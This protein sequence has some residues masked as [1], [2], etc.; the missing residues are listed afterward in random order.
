MIS[1]GESGGS[2]FRGRAEIGR[3]EHLKRQQYLRRSYKDYS[4][5]FQVKHCIPLENYNI[6]IRGRPDGVYTENGAVMIEEIKTI[7]AAGESFRNLTLQNLSNFKTQMDLYCF[8]LSRERASENFACRLYLVNLAA[9]EARTLDYIPDMKDI[10]SVLHLTLNQLA[11]EIERRRQHHLALKE[12]ADRLKFPYPEYRA[13][14]QKMIEYVEAVCD[15]G[16]RMILSAPTGAGKTAG[17]LF[18]ALRSAFR[19]GKQLYFATAR[20]TQRFIVRDYLLKLKEQSLPFNAIFLTA[21]SKLCPLKSEFCDRQHCQYTADF[22][23][24]LQRTGIIEDFDSGLIHDADKILGLS[25]PVR[26]C[27]FYVQLAL[28]YRADVVT[29]DFNYVFDPAISIRQMFSEDRDKDFILI[30]DEAHNLPARVRNYFSPALS[31]ENVSELLAGLQGKGFSD[32]LHLNFVKFM[33]RVLKFIGGYKGEERRIEIDFEQ[34]N[35]LAEESEKLTLEYF[36]HLIK[37]GA[38]AAGDP[39]LQLLQSVSGFSRAAGMQSGSFAALYQ[40]DGITIKLLCLDSGPICNDT[41][42]HFHSVT[43]MSATLFPHEYFINQLGMGEDCEV[44]SLPNPFPQENRKIAIAASIST[45]YQVRYKFNAKLAEI[46]EQVYQSNPGAYFCFFPAFAYMNSLA[47]HLKIPYLMQNAGMTEDDRREY[48]REVSAGGKMFL[49]VMGGIFAEGVDYPGQLNGIIIV[50]PGLPLFCL[51]QELQR[52]HYQEKY[53]KGFEY[54]YLYPGMN[55]VIQAAG[56]LIRSESDRGV[57]ILADARFVQEPYRS[58]IPQEWYID[59]PE[60]LLIK[61]INL[62][63]SRFWERW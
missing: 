24:R 50:G 55:R 49:A 18:P 23:S 38:E 2:P 61:D 27:P 3:R 40:P 7:A 51:E 20:T 28:A 37:Y 54:A 1:P 30:I 46:I 43:A 52:E 60:E 10:E 4:G 48:L 9:D 19:S 26:L 8:L 16:G 36:F 42:S 47:E 35:T 12:S 14:Q 25:E 21:R 31:G 17:A 53:G 41:L 33:R 32:K 6:I 13:H 11:V 22:D 29:G 5:E 15:R 58:L 57:I 59:S 39:V 45:R 56:R 44:L 62:E 34:L 63:L